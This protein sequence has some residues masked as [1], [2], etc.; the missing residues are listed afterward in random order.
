MAEEKGN[1]SFSSTAVQTKMKAIDGLF[2]EFAA[3]LKYINDDIQTNVNVGVDSAIFG[4]YGTAIKSAWDENAA[5]FGDFY[6]NFNNWSALVSA[7]TANNIDLSNEAIALYNS[8]G[9]KLDGVP[10]AVQAIKDGKTPAKDSD[11]ELVYDKYHKNVEEI[12]EN[13]KVVGYKFTDSS[14]N[15]ITLKQKNGKWV[16][17]DKD[18]KEI[19]PY[20]KSEKYMESA[21]GSKSTNTYDA[22]NDEEKDDGTKDTESEENKEEDNGVPKGVDD[23]DSKETHKYSSSDAYWEK[24]TNKDGSTVEVEY[25][26]DGT[27]WHERYTDA[28][29]NVTETTK[30]DSNG[31][32]VY[33]HE[34]DIENVGTVNGHEVYKSTHNDANSI[35]PEGDD[36]DYS[37][38]TYY[39]RD[40][41]G[42][43]VSTTD[44]S[45]NPD[46]ELPNETLPEEPEGE[47]TKD[48]K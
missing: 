46:D 43:H 7:A 11:A 48:T 39:Y 28:N 4:E 6:K 44:P 1:V 45:I 42:G 10:E 18:G 29:G 30:Y 16:Y 12:V 34:W 17:T 47:V 14:G 19:N 27:K 36:T 13:G 37:G 24:Y 3:V 33:H 26:A 20:E 21:S 35:I 9:D 2:S 5:T 32:V 22:G 8:T 23:P 38:S 40:E 31:D 25:H 41:T 15:E